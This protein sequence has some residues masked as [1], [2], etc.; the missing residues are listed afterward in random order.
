MSY[1]RLGVRHVKNQE[2]T[3]VIMDEN[4]VKET[5]HIADMETDEVHELV[6]SKGFERRFGALGLGPNG[7]DES[8]A[9]Y[10]KSAKRALARSRVTPP[11]GPRA[12]KH[13]TTSPLARSR[14]RR[15][16]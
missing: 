6:Q 4:G 12:L 3:L 15:E 8:E 2:P 5:V 14:E 7:G 10:E 9:E 16:E 13:G 11:R 1:D